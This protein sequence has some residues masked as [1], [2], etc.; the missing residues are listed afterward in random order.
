MKIVTTTKS[1]V[2]LA[3]IN[4]VFNPKEIIPFIT[5]DAPLAAQP[6]NTGLR[7]CNER[8]DYVK[9]TNELGE[10]DL[11]ISIENGIDT[12]THFKKGGDHQHFVDICYAVIEDKDG[13]RYESESF[14]IPIKMKYVENARKKTSSNYKYSDLG[15]EITAGSMI[16]EEFPDIDHADWMKDPRFFGKSRVEQIESALNLLLKLITK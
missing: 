8:I 14:A 11:I 13:N 4:K 3:A 12:K 10:Y 5:T 1:A 7:C 2:K 16:A 9:A 6:M 15:L